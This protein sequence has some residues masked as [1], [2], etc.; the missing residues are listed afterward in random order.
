M[1]LSTYMVAAVGAY[2]YARRAGADIPA[3]SLPV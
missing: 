1:M 2:L 3:L